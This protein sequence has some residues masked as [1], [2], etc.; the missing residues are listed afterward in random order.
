[1]LP[2]RPKLGILIT[3]TVSGTYSCRSYPF[4]NTGHRLDDVWHTLIPTLDK[5]FLALVISLSLKKRINFF[6]V[7]LMPE[8]CRSSRCEY[9]T[10]ER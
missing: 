3:E 6:S 10:S 2:D 7:Q 8:N 1:M 5:L 4:G 9:C